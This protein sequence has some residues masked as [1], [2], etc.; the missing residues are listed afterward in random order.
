MTLLRGALAALLLT[1]TL[2]AQIS[3]GR[4]VFLAN[5]SFCHA[6]GGEG[7]R[8]PSL[9]TAASV[10]GRDKASLTR[11]ITKG[12]PGSQMPAFTQFQPG[13]LQPL[14]DFVQSLSASAPK[15]ERAPGDPQ[16]GATLFARNRCASCHRINS[17]GS[18][19]GPDLTRIGAGR[20]LKHLRESLTNPEADIMPEFQGVVVTLPDGSR[21]SGVRINE[22]TFT[23][24]LRDLAQNFRLFKKDEVKA[25]EPSKRSLMPPYKLP[26]AEL[27]NLV[28]YLATLRGPAA[29]KDSKQA[30]GIR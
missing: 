25:V 28:A 1:S 5:C 14:V 9:T 10:H 18:V 2:R 20:S 23:V 12:V 21:V 16:A 8:G 15:S 6:A 24:Q 26:P 17:Q 19:F 3:T 27:D 30:G 22:D 11:V 29:A 7:G 13:E 4:A